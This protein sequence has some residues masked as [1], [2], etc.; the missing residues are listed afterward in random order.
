MRYRYRRFQNKWWP[1][2][3]VP[4]DDISP[5]AISQFGSRHIARVMRPYPMSSTLP[6]MRYRY[7]TRSDITSQNIPIASLIASLFH[8]CLRFPAIINPG[9]NEKLGFITNHAYVAFS[10]SHSPYIILWPTPMTPPIAILWYSSQPLDL[11][12]RDPT[13]RINS[14]LQYFSRPLF[15]PNFTYKMVFSL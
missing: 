7:R 12:S 4:S 10:L 15:S 1:A 14:A 8:I 2:F 13:A 11:P 5:I 6:P 9:F 3:M